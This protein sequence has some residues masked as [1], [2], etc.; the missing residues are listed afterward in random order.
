MKALV[1]LVTFVSAL[2]LAFGQGFGLTSEVRGRIVV[3]GPFPVRFP[4][5][6]TLMFVNDRG[7]T[8]ADMTING[9]VKTTSFTSGG[10][11]GAILGDI[12]IS[13]DGKFLLRLPP[14]EHRV[15]VRLRPGAKSNAT[16]Y[17]V[18]G[19]QS[20]SIDLAE[21][22]LAVNRSSNSE[23]VLTLEKCTAETRTQC[24]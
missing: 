10:G 3:A 9:N 24:G 5:E 2:S 17:F 1:V 11:R 21:K 12:H 22:P 14:G 7:Q 19:V 4:D 15:L 18:K 6:I 16:T 13:E 20:G 23:L 8:V